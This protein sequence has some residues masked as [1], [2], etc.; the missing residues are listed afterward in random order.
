MSDESPK[1]AARRQRLK[2]KLWEKVEQQ[3]RDMWRPHHGSTTHREDADGNQMVEKKKSGGHM[4]LN[5]A[6]MARWE[7]KEGKQRKVEDSRQALARELY[8]LATG[9]PLEVVCFSEIRDLFGSY[10]AGDSDL[11]KLREKA[12]EHG[13][14]SASAARLRAIETGIDLMI[15]RLMVE[16]TTNK[17]FWADFPLEGVPTSRSKSA[18]EKARERYLIFV[19]ECEKRR[20][21][22]LDE[23][24][25]KGV[26]PPETIRVRN[27]ALERTAD[28]CGVDKRTVERAVQDYESGYLKEETS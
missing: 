18:E 8:R 1:Q 2:E 17:A 16:G 4:P 12:A 11:S 24:A 19:E 23:Y 14:T 22:K 28:R 13:P 9:T 6:V 27:K 21:E 7:P 3:L 26:E 25:R 10:G 15:E 20:Q 5:A